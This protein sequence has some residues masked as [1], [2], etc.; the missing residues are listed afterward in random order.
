MYKT[1]PPPVLVTAF[2]VDSFIYKIQFLCCVKVFNLKTS[3]ITEKKILSPLKIE[4]V[5]L[6]I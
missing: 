1:P 3:A 6:W 5:N 2:Q 4:S